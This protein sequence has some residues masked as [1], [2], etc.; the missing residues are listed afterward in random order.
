L[1]LDNIKV[2]GVYDEEDGSIHVDVS[3][4]QTEILCR[5]C[6]KPT[7]PHGF[8]R[9][10]ILR[11]VSLLLHKVYVEIT[12]PRGICKNC[13]KSTTTTQTLGWYNRNG[14]HTKLYNDY[15]MLQLIGTTIVDIAKK[16]CLSED[17]LQGVMDRCEIDKVDWKS[18]KRIGLL[19]IDEI[20][21]KKGYQNY[22]TLITSNYNGLTSIL[23]IVKGKKYADIKGFLASIPKKKRKTITSVCV[24]MCDG[25]ISAVK[26]ELG[27]DIPI[28]VDRFH[29]A[30]LYRKS[31]TKLRSD[32]LRRLRRELSED[33]YKE[34]SP[35]I[36]ILIKNS[37]C[38]SKQDK[39]VI[40]PLFKHSP[41]IK[42]AY[43]LARELTHIYN[44]HHRK[45]TAK[46]K[47]QVW[48]KKVECSDVNC[49]NTFIKTLGKYEDH[50]TN[51]FIN[52]DTSGW[53][54]GLNN[55][56]KV[57]KRRCYGLTNL[58]HFFQRIFL[59]LRGYDIFL[60]EQSLSVQ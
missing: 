36:K 10:L 42:A 2:N 49:L 21:N 43:R 5:E 34:L 28:V 58:K 13:D 53:V 59:D 31:I 4:T 6:H 17:I 51:Y 29:V 8:G 37:E 7:E 35:A 18:I 26:D 55:K 30:K 52:R 45:S 23:G 12:P 22:I 15:L 47:I 39:K 16:E 11:H 24:D 46:K 60:P 14:H 9:P 38:Y 3:S 20:A 41:A 50:I 19:G 57:I 48:V 25:Y 32:E 40:E 54:E 44:T 33:E 1:G 27:T 56:F